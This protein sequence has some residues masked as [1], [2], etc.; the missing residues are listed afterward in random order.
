M[1]VL[2]ELEQDGRKLEFRENERGFEKVFKFDLFVSLKGVVGGFE[3]P[4]WGL[5][6]LKELPYSFGSGGMSWVLVEP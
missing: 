3:E 2:E 6:V 4:W 1:S 5:L